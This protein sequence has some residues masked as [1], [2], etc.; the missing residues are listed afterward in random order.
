MAAQPYRLLN[1][2]ELS[3]Q[4]GYPYS[5]LYTLVRAGSLPPHGQSGSIALFEERRLSEV[6]ERIREHLSPIQR[7]RLA[8]PCNGRMNIARSA[9]RSQC[10]AQHSL[11]NSADS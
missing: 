7:R 2:S 1:L 6:D 5:L 9:A 10:G 4:L 8:V 11:R 3:R